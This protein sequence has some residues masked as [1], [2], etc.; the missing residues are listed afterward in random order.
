MLKLTNHIHQVSGCKNLCLAGGVALNVGNGR[1]LREGPF[2]N[3]WIQPASGD[4]GGAL[5]RALLLAPD[6]GQVRTRPADAGSRD[7]DAM[8]AYPA[9]ST[10]TTRSTRNW[11]NSTR[12]TSA[13]NT[14]RPRPPRRDPR[15]RQGHR[16]LRWSQ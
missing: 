2:E 15:R 13:S 11:T 12:S 3:I 16:P 1:V 6:D 8:K 5:R 10:P 4:A 7:P 14:T 9:R